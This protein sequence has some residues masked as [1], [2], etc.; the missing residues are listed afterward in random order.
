MIEVYVGRDP[1]TLGSQ[2]VELL[3]ASIEKWFTAKGSLRR[4]FVPCVL[5]RASALRFEVGPVAFEFIDRITTSEFYPR[6]DSEEA[7]LGRIG[8]DRLLQWMRERDGDWMAQVSVDGCEQK[9][10]E[11]IA[12]LTV[13][14]AIVALQLAAPYLDTRAMTR[15]DAR[16][17]SSQKLTLSETDGYYNF[18]WRRQEPGM[19]IGQGV[20]SDMLQTAAPLFAAV[21]NVL[22]SF[23]SGS[24]R[25]VILEQAWCDSAYW[26]HQALVESIDSIAVA[27][28]ET[29]L[30]VLLRSESSRGSERRMLVILKTFFE[31][32]PD[33]T[34]APG[35]AL[36]ARQ[37]ARNLVRDRSRILHGTWSTLNVRG[38]DRGGLEGFVI[39]VLRSAA[40]QLDLYAKS[41]A[42][43]D[44]VDAFLD[45]VCQAKLINAAR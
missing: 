16:R 34:V 6:G 17:G 9:R 20:L 33:D 3:F 41:V 19:V 13:D 36:S 31:L 11:E 4:V 28:L 1:L 21:G 12:E 7:V 18:A 37:F 25:L 24:F 40:I 15:L 10:S 29:A 43:V 2:D 8:F 42:P 26:F 30:E 5:S 22:R 14:L 27:K 35:S 44:D 38:I 32:D 39:T 23:A 45:W